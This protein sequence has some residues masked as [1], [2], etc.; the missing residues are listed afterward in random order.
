MIMYIE[1]LYIDIC[2]GSREN[3]WAIISAL[4]V[5]YASNITKTDHLVLIWESTIQLF[6]EEFQDVRHR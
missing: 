1:Y 2:F 6:S 5:F 3:V 4:F